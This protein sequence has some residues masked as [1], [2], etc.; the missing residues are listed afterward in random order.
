MLRPKERSEAIARYAEERG[1]TLEQ[2][3]KALS[4]AQDGTKIHR[5]SETLGLTIC[6]ISSYATRCAD[7]REDVTCQRCRCH[8]RPSRY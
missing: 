3:A 7:E 1:V 2:A 8:L 4:L 6:G 5:P